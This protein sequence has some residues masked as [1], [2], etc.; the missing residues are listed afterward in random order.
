MD[1]KDKLPPTIAM[2]KSAPAAEIKPEQLRNLSAKLTKTF[3]RFESDRRMAEMKWARNL[4]QYLGV[5]DPEIERSMPEGRSRAYPRITRVKCVSVLSRLMNLMFPGNERNWELKASPSADLPP[6]E[7]VAAI[8]ELVQ[9]SQEEG[10]ENIQIDDGMVQDAVDNIARQ[11]ADLLSTLIDDQMQE[12]GGDQTSDYVRLNRRVAMSGIQYGLGYLRGPMVRQTKQ[13]VWKMGQDGKPQASEK[14]AYRPQYEFMPVWDVYLDMDARCPE[15][16]EGYFLRIVMSRAQLRNLAAREDFFAAQVKRVIK[17]NPRGNYKPKTFETEIKSIGVKEAS[18]SDKEE[19][20]K[21]EVIIWHGPINGKMLADCGVEVPEE[22]LQDEVNAEVWMVGDAVIKAVMDPWEYL[23]VNMRQLHAFVFDEDD[24]S[25]IGNGLP[26][27]M[28]DSQMAICAAT[29]MLLDNASVACGP[30]VEVNLDLLEPD[31]DVNSIHSFKIWQRFGMGADANVPALRS[32]NIDSHMTELLQIIDLFSRL[33]DQETFVGP[34]TGGDMERGLAEPMR[35]AAGASMLR[36]EAALPFKDIVRNF[37]A[38]TQSLIQSLVM[39]N[40]KF[41]PDKVPDGDYN[42][43][44]RGATSLI[45]KEIRG[46]QVDQLAQTLSP[47]ERVYVDEEKLVEAR[48]KT[49]DLDGMLVSSDE[50]KRRRA[51]QS[52]TQKQLEEMQA[53]TAEAEI[54]KLVSDAFKNVT[55]GQKNTANADATAIQSVINAL[56]KGVEMNVKEQESGARVISELENAAATAEQRERGG[57]GPA[58]PSGQ[59]VG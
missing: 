22:K 46:A 41:N 56:S 26:N 55:Q 6:D 5:Y 30:Q 16:S 8:E 54:R 24:T 9:K 34:A 48:F 42:V 44:A 19:T 32:L 29:R 59:Q 15:E 28:R 14:V 17:E 58:G 4:R 10:I 27:V 31:Q 35:T 39:F 1:E 3:A 12:L 23:G 57:S 25:P 13:T 2:D 52:Q 53:K 37:D 40:K 38:F 33:A 43:I 45:A 50:A 7:V 47:E 20:G 18:Q 21:Y 51:A 49:R 11:R 36:G